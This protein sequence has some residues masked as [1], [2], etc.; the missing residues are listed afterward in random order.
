MSDPNHDLQ[1]R[2]I[3]LARRSFRQGCYVYT[4]FLTVAEQELLRRIPFSSDCAPY[5]FCGGYEWS[6]RKLARFGSEEL[7]GFSEAPPITCLAIRPASANFAEMLSHRDY[8]GA[9]MSLGVCREVLGDIVM[10]K[11]AAYLFCLS[12]LANYICEQLSRVRRTAVTCVSLDALPSGVLPK[13]TPKELVVA[14]ERADALIAAVYKLSRRE[15]RGL[16]GTGKVLV[17]DRQLLN[18]DRL[19]RVGQR[20]SVRGHGRFVYKGVL[21]Q[22]AKERL[23]V[24]VTVS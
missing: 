15:S 19:L 22:T 9:L 11:N 12:G 10:D 24:L 18:P 23:W 17:D 14:T 16:I 3:E 20:V 4:D 13:S 6:E 5:S 2:F 1:N 8:L 21:R 7:C